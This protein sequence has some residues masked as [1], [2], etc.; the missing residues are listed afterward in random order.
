M[1]LPPEALSI[2]GS[3][4][5][6]RISWRMTIPSLKDRPYHPN[7]DPSSKLAPVYL[8]YIF[9]DHCNDCRN[10]TGSI[11]PAWISGSLDYLEVSFRDCS[12]HD[13]EDYIPGKD[14]IA[15]PHK[16]VKDYLSFYNSSPG[17]YRSFCTNCGTHLFFWE[18]RL[19]ELFDVALGTVVREQLEQLS[20]ERHLWW[21]R[22]LPWI[23]DYLDGG[24]R[25]N[26]ERHVESQ[27]N[28]RYLLQG[29]K[30]P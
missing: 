1:P 26:I 30:S 16:F 23:K 9:T 4:N 28:I 6:R 3:C 12:S 25:G 27:M 15:R 11:L 14:A 22:A 10:A 20:P 29:E 19:P 2:N 17:K 5:C 8:P 7:F 24:D 18:E 21:D 13:V